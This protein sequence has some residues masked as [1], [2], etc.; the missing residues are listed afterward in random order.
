[1]SSPTI[2]LNSVS[3]ETG[4]KQ[5]KRLVLE[6]VNWLIKPRT[7]VVILGPRNSGASALLEIIAGLTLPTSGWVDRRAIVSVPGGGLLRYSRHDTTR[8]LISRL[9]LVYDVDPKEIVEFVTSALERS[10]LLDIPTRQV[11]VALRQQVSTALT[12]A[13]P[14]DFYLFSSAS[15]GGGEQRFQAFCQRAFE[16]RSRHAGI[17]MT[18]NSGKSA[19]RFG[20]DMLGALVHQGQLTLYRR[21][22]DAITV[23]ESLP[24]ED[25]HPEELLPPD[26]PPPYYEE[27]FF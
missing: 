14:C 13:F 6:D 25:A 3:H 16:L 8:Q 10:D 4:R 20:N 23:F 17:I 19:R 22:S 18:T 5:F 12:Y 7:R 1:M 15:V 21:L 11:P 26:N 27:E 24:P 9:S 2:T